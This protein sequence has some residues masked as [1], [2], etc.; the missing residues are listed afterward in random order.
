MINSNMDP[1][2][3]PHIKG[4]TIKGVEPLF[5]AIR[6]KTDTD[7]EERSGC[8]T[9]PDAVAKTLEA[10]GADSGAW[11]KDSLKMSMDEMKAEAAKLG[12]GEIKRHGHD[13]QHAVVMKPR[14]SPT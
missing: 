9:F 13:A 8:M 11:L 10:K 14:S 4:A 5:E 6:N 1:V 3:Q 7:W 2:D 12:V